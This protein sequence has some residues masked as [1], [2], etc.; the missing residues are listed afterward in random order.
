MTFEQT[1]YGIDRHMALNHFGHVTL[2]SHLL[3]LIKKTAESNHTIRIVNQASNAHQSAPSDVKFA[4]VAELNK[5]LG[6]MGQY[7]RSKLANILYSRYLNKHLTSAH[8][9]ILVNATHPGFVE[10]A[11][12]TRDIHE[13]YPLGGYGMSVA[14]KPLKKDNFQGAVS[15]LFAATKTEKSGQYVCPPAIPEPGTDKAQDLELAEQL[16]KLTRDVIK[17]KTYNESAAKGCPFKDY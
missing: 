3:P 1:D 2:T 9:N 6:A 16:M 5:D 7:G 17:E 4:D 11:M 14:M 13:P 12:S 15:T 10:T 8:P